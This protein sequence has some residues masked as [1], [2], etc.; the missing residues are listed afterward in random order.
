MDY[1][2]TVKRYISQTKI[3]LKK[4]NL[5]SSALDDLIFLYSDALFKYNF[6]NEQYEKEG[7]PLTVEFEGGNGFVSEKTDPRIK[8]LDTL[9]KD[10]ALLAT[11]LGLTVKYARDAGVKKTEKIKP[12]SLAVNKVLTLKAGNG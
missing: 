4:L 9:R 5:Y 3:K 6:I 12:L 8:I 11:N 2:K 7:F 1:G 10:I